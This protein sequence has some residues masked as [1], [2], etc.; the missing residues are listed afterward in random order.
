MCRDPHA[1]HIIYATSHGG[2]EENC[3]RNKIG[4]TDW[5]QAC[6]LKV[7]CDSVHLMKVLS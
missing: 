4:P 6:C 3:A 5:L 1:D 7:S 2:S